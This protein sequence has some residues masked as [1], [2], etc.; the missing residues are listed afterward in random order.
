MVEQFYFYQQHREHSIVA[1]GITCTCPGGNAKFR[2]RQRRLLL[3]GEAPYQRNVFNDVSSSCIFGTIG[4]CAK[5]RKR[6]ATVSLVPVYSWNSRVPFLRY[7]TSSLS[8]CL[9]FIIIH[10]VCGDSIQ[11]YPENTCTRLITTPRV[12]LSL[13]VSLV[14][15]CVCTWCWK[16]AVNA[17]KERHTEAVK[18]G[19]FTR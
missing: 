16:R 13:S 14:C 8:S 17:W 6:D 7:C 18:N 9:I 12:S 3:R 10:R 19:R 11:R 5:R 4:G 15:V 2:K 1:K